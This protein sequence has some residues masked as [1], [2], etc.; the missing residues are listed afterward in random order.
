MASILCDRWGNNGWCVENARLA[1]SA[2][3]PQGFPLTITGN[4]GQPFTCGAD[5]VVSLSEGTGTA[6]FTVT[7]N[8]GQ[9]ASGSLDWKYD[10]SLPTSDLQVN[11]T[12]GANG[13][14]VS[15]VN[16]S[17][18]GSD[19]VSG[20]ASNEVSINGGTWQSSANFSDGV[21]Q[22]QA[23]SLDNAG[24][25]TLSLA[26]KIQVDTVKPDLV[27]TPT[28]IQ[29]NKGY[30]RSAVTISLVGNDATSG[31]AQLEYSLDGGDW[32]TGDTLTISADGDHSLEGRATDNAGNQ[33]LKAIAIHID[34]IPPVAKFIMPPEGATTTVQGAISFGGDIYDVG[35]GVE[36][37]ELSLDEGKTWKTLLLVNGIWRYDWITMVFPNGKYRIFA[38]G[39]D[40]A[41][42]VQEPPSLTTLI[43]ENQPP[44]I[45][46]QES[47]FVWEAGW[48]KIEEREGSPLESVSVTVRDPQGRWDDVVWSYQRDNVPS[49]IK[50]DGYFTR[51]VL[52]PV[53]EYEVIAIARDI[54]GRQASDRGTIMIPLVP[55]TA[56]PTV[57]TTPSPVPSRMPM[58][59]Q[60]VAPTQAVVVTSIP[61][62]VAQ[63]VSVPAKRPLVLWP[64]V[65]LVGLLMALASASLSDH[66]PQA[67]RRLIKAIDQIVAQNKMGDDK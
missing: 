8:S 4:V 28:G 42:N 55:V 32:V 7:S 3:D 27:I 50:W 35:S 41:G 1:I 22:I 11:G 53:G 38:R 58:P 66:R 10:A 24:W 25:E 13:W 47:W 6:T 16:I 63:P 23:H 48:L 60:T 67:I 44:S 65:G 14:Y 54:Y 12:V 33:T 56:T 19:A 57:T 52:A 21:Y 64:T 37:V 36:H 30:F 43:V 34:K 29:G 45:S 9:A 51:G 5:C 2:Y 40:I 31:I 61:T 49:E 59:T 62:A 17:P 20:L 46:I 26:Q 18:L 15:N 39:W